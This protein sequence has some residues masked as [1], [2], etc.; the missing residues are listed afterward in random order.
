MKIMEV[1]F[2]LEWNSIF[3]PIKFNPIQNWCAKKRNIRKIFGLPKK[4]ISGEPK[5]IT[6]TFVDGMPKKIISGKPKI[7]AE[8]FVDGM[9]KII[10]TGKPNVSLNSIGIS[11]IIFGQPNIMRISRQADD[12]N[13]SRR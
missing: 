7:I 13:R 10:I 1:D 8:I 3:T 4:I 9:P 11:E 12:K 6:E 2:L 5:I